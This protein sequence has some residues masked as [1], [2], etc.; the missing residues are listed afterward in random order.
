MA[1]QEH[2]KLRLSGPGDVAVETG[3]EYQLLSCDLLSGMALK[4]Q[5]SDPNRFH[6]HESKCRE[7]DLSPQYSC[8]CFSNV[9]LTW[10]SMN[11]QGRSSRM[12]RIRL[13]LEVSHQ[14]I[15]Y[16]GN[17]FFFWHLFTQMMSHWVNFMPSLCSLVRSHLLSHWFLNIY[18][19]YIYIL[20]PLLYF[21]IVHW[22]FNRGASLLSNW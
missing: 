15:K 4:M 21:R 13:S 12:V 20:L 11:T 16:E 19:I 22:K 6:Y 14:W 17:T 7:D 5:A 3:R 1:S 9:S 2:K 18:Y 8:S 10:V